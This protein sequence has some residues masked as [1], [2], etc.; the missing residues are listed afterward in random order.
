MIT[1]II[2]NVN[3]FDNFELIFKFQKAKFLKN[4][5]IFLTN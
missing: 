2:P 1:I 5:P 3:T 4:E